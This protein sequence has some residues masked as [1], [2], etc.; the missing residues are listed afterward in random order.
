VIQCTAKVEN[1]YSYYVLVLYILEQ[2]HEL[3]LQLSED[4]P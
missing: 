3:G 1:H 2:A 4:S